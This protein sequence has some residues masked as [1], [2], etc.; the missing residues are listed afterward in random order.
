MLPHSLA[1]CSYGPSRHSGEP[2][3]TNRGGAFVQ[4]R[5]WARFGRLG[6]IKG[7]TCFVDSRPVT[8]RQLR[9]WYMK[10]KAWYISALFLR[11]MALTIVPNYK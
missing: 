2:S 4:I 6:D 11:I 1:M 8:F 9:T 10:L 5:P 7:F 3:Y